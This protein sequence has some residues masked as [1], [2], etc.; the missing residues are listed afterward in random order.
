M[1]LDFVARRKNGEGTYYIQKNGKYK[2]YVLWILED[3]RKLSVKSY[4]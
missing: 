2:Y 4:S 1:G 3:L